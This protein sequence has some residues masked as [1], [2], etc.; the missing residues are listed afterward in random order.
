MLRWTIPYS[1]S[2]MPSKTKTPSLTPWQ[3]K[4]G[5]GKDGACGLC[6]DAGSEIG[7]RVKTKACWDVLAESEKRVVMI[8]VP[9]GRNGRAVPGQ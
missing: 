9:D 1:R 2:T 5:G 7:E 8:H 3:F 4:A 6:H